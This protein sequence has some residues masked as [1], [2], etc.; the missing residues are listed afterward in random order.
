M[1]GRTLRVLLASSLVVGPA[2]LSA[3]A[4][5]DPDV[6]K[7]IQQVED[8]D[9]DA[10]IVTLDAAARR[11][12][13]DPS[14]P[15]DLP[16]T[17]LY[18]GIAFVGKGHEAAAK[19][20]FR[21]ALLQ[22]RDLTLSADKF[23]PKVIDLFESARFELARE[24]REPATPVPVPS[25]T[26]ASALIAP[27]KKGGS[28]KA[29]LIVGSSSP[30][31]TASGARTTTTFANEVVVF[32]GGRDYAI[33]VAGSGTLDA[34]VDWQQDGV[35]LGMYIVNLANAGRVL[36]DGSQTATKQ[37]SLSLAVTPG[38]YRVSVNNSTGAGPHVDTTF[39][40]TV[41]HP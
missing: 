26:R 38:S 11:L 41:V 20:R 7:G 5:S 15:R 8:G 27:P 25:P 32:G 3:Q 40:L 14:H 24:A 35:L 16:Q 22:L 13:A 21:D 31:P 17:Y 19:A 6:A 4:P 1:I 34:R 28:S 39:T 12:A 23:P 10:A 9:Y 36:A 37:V 29:L 18:L 30:A 2:P 33:T